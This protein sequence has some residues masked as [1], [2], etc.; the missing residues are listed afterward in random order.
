MENDVDDP[1]HSSF[2]VLAPLLVIPHP[3]A[4][5]G[6]VGKALNTCSRPSPAWLCATW[7]K[8]QGHRRAGYGPD[9]WERF[10]GLLEPED[11]VWE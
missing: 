11:P 4:E 3:R 8:P 10:A 9:H 7:V 2:L 1:H 6:R 5:P